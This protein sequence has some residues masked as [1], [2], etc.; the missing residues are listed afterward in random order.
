[1]IAIAHLHRQV[2]LH[3]LPN[4]ESFRH[5]GIN[6]DNGNLSR[7]GGCFDRPEQCL[8]RGVA[9]MPV[10]VLLVGFRRDQLAFRLVL[11][12]I[13]YRLV[14]RRPMMRMGCI[15]PNGVYDPINPDAARKPF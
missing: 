13:E 7:L 15:H 12:A 4:R 11:A 9:G 8:R 14:R 5:L 2:L 3:R 6:T 1:M 10:S